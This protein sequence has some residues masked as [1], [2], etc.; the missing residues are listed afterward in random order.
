MTRIMSYLGIR[1]IRGIQGIQG[2]TTGHLNSSIGLMHLTPVMS[3]AEFGPLVGKSATGADGALKG[4]SDRPALM[5]QQASSAS[6]I[7]QFLNSLDSLHSIL[8]LHAQTL[9]RGSRPLPCS[10]T[11]PAP[12][13]AGS[14]PRS[15][16]RLDCMPYYPGP[17]G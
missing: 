9:P 8:A 12:V 5:R 16:R 4:G 1:G 15:R 14:R 17:R 3:L 10:W 13:P 2:R 7:L 6:P 11:L